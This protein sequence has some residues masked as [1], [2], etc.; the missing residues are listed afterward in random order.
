MAEARAAGRVLPG[1]AAPCHMWL[2]GVML[3]YIQ[4]TP[5]AE[6]LPLTPGNSANVSLRDCPGS[7]CPLN[8]GRGMNEELARRS[9]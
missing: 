7:G 4:P 5:D 2:F 9:G 1:A 6:Y 3:D 8:R